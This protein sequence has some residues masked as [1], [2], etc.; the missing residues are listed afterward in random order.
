MG[1]NPSRVKGANLPVENVSW[2]DAVE[3]CKKLTAR[4]R[5]AGVISANQEYRLPTNEEWEYACRAGTTT[6]YYTGNTE[7]DL[8]RAGWY[9]GNS[10]GKPHPVGQKLPN[11]FGLYDM[12]GSVCEW[13]SS[14][15]TYE[16]FLKIK[17]DWIAT[18][19][20]SR[21]DFPPKNS[22]E[23][24]SYRVIRSGSW[25]YPA[26]L[27]RSSILSFF[28]P[29]YRNRFFGFRVAVVQTSNP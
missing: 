24:S 12:H 25:R 26:L 10:D 5:A 3:F 1:K 22:K 6:A 11:A 20:F 16:L 8:A 2:N 21:E 23:L 14:I 7:A 17:E 29:E 28:S 18:G 15:M 27:C 19:L 9:G 4:E 13:T